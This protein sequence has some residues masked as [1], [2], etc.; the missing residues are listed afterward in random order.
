MGQMRRFFFFFFFDNEFCI[1]TLRKHTYIEKP[2]PLDGDILNKTQAI[3]SYYLVLSV[4]L[5]CDLR[6]KGALWG[7]ADKGESPSQSYDKKEKQT[8]KSV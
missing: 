8:F 7:H 3:I 5:K 6:C 2:P 1:L 4:F